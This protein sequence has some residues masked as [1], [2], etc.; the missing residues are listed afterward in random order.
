MAK[1]QKVV[2]TRDIVEKQSLQ[3]SIAT[4]LPLDIIYI[5]GLLSKY[6]SQIDRSLAKHRKKEEYQKLPQYIYDLSEKRRLENIVKK[7]FSLHR[8]LEAK[9]AEEELQNNAGV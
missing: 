3:M 7:L 1:T 2:E 5:Y 9:K 6:G 8:S 4:L